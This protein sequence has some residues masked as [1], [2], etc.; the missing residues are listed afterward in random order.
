MERGCGGSCAIMS[1][2]PRFP[3][4]SPSHKLNGTY[5]I[6]STPHLHGCDLIFRIAGSFIMRKGSGM[7]LSAFGTDW[8]IPLRC[9]SAA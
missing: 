7:G 2:V 8:I 1:L 6:Y 9:A 3:D 5:C 4:Q